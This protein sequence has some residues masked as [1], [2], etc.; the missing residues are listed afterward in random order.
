MHITSKEVYTVKAFD[1]EVT[2]Y[3]N[4]NIDLAIIEKEVIKGYNHIGELLLWFRYGYYS[5]LDGL[6]IGNPKN[7]TKA[8]F[9]EYYSLNHM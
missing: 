6:L 1:G 3:V 4:K 7:I 5:D 9:R 8:E 2:L